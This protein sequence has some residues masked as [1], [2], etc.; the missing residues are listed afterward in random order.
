MRPPFDHEFQRQGFGP[1]RHGGFG[2]FGPAGWGG[3]PPGRG[4]HGGRHGGPG[5]GRRGR[6]GD[7]RAA[8]LVLLAEQ[9]RHGYEIIGEIGERSGG[10][11]RPSP[12][13]I[14]PTLQLLADEGLVRSSEDSG[15]RLYELTEEG[16]AAA[17]RHDGTP[18]WE[19]FTQDADPR[20]IELRDATGTLIGAARQM[21]QVGSSAQKAKA[22]EVLNEARRALY[23]ILGDA[24]PP[25]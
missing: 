6:R 10:L 21:S 16:R 22:V 15:K 3:F 7:I 11:W 5:R 12:G 20:E 13:S 9:P 24:S 25:D 4:P 23:G 18:P 14:Y 8:I 19:H 1:G 17:H 2:G